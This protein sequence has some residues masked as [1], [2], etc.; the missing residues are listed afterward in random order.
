MNTVVLAFGAVF[1]LYAIQCLIT[2]F[3]ICVRSL[4]D[5][6]LQKIRAQLQ[7][8]NILGFALLALITLYLSIGLFIKLSR[9]APLY[10]LIAPSAFYFANIILLILLDP[11]KIKGLEFKLRGPLVVF[12]SKPLQYYFSPHKPLGI[13]ALAILGILFVIGL[14][15]Q[16]T[17]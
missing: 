10:V 4:F 3:V 15:L 13:I 1:F 17:T 16:F 7:E 8:R 6:R 9:L 2:G 14:I 12:E 5:K 11:Q